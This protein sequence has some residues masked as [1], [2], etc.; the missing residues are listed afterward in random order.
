[1][2]APKIEQMFFP[3]RPAGCHT[4]LHQQNW[5]FLNKIS[6]YVGPPSDELPDAPIVAVWRIHWKKNNV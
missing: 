6:I 2:K 4:T 5:N 3:S 1:M